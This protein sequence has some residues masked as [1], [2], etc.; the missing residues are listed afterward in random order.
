MKFILKAILVLIL[1]CCQN[2]KLEEIE[3]FTYSNVNLNDTLNP[4]F[5]YSN[6][7]LYKIG[8]QSGFINL[9]KDTVIPLGKYSINWTDTFT[10]FA[11]VFDKNNTNNKAVGIN[12]KEEILFDIH[13]YDNYPDEMSEGLF[14]VKK[15]NKIGFANKY[16]QIVIP[17]IY[18]C[19]FSFQNGKAQVTKKCTI[20]TDEFEHQIPKSD[21]WFFIDKKGNKI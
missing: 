4:L 3:T 13:F 2:K 20:E 10:T 5:R 6:D 19:A 12:Q 15:N 21:N 11:I 17:C 8:S 16:G 7:S 1:I 9:K 14:R 18:E